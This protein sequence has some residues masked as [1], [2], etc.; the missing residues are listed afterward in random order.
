MELEFRKIL[1]ERADKGD[2]PQSAI[3]KILYDNP[4]R[5]YAL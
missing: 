1:Q 3:Q 5:F 2:I 4:K